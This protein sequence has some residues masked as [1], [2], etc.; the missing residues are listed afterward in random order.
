MVTL[1]LECQRSLTTN[2]GTR[3]WSHSTDATRHINVLLTASSEHPC[4]MRTSHTMT[5]QG[6][7]V[8]V[9]LMLQAL[10]SRQHFV[11]AD[12]LLNALQVLLL[13]AT[14]EGCWLLTLWCDLCRPAF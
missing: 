6:D 2:G 1:A 4:P 10:L 8:T 3:S 5:T 7:E 11:H 12:S 9:E 13:D 14:W